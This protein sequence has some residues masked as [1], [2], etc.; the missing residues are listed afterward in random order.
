VLTANLARS[1]LVR[2]LGC[3][4]HLTH[5]HF[6]SSTGDLTVQISNGGALFSALC[7]A[8]EALKHLVSFSLKYNSSDEILLSL[9]RSCQRTLKQLDVEHS[10]NLGGSSVPLLLMFNNL[11]EL[12]IA[13]T[14]LSPSD[15]A[16]LLQGLTKIRSLPRGEFLCEALHHWSATANQEMPLVMIFDLL[17]F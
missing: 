8:L 11:E 12:A 15:C 17:I 3:L 4:P 2:H 10:R 6:G 1:S 13:K 9:T 16:L 5:L 14:N 7:R